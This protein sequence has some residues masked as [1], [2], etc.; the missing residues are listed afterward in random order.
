MAH[1]RTDRVP[2]WLRLTPHVPFAPSRGCI[3]P[4]LA[5]L[6]LVAKITPEQPRNQTPKTPFILSQT[7]ETASVPPPSR[8]C[9]NPQNRKPPP[10]AYSLILG[11]VCL[12]FLQIDDSTKELHSLISVASSVSFTPTMG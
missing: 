10:V 4:P 3:V 5:P 7:C 2:E 8:I 9:A 12:K 1:D 6:S 11:L